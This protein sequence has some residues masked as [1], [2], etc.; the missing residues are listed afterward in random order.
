L[1]GIPVTAVAATV[2]ILALVQVM[3]PVGGTFAALGVAPPFGGYFVYLGYLEWHR[4]RIFRSDL[5][6]RTQQPPA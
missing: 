5:R 4:L 2:W 6:E 1:W 3:E